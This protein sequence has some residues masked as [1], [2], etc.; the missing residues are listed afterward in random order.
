MTVA[1][2]V[3]ETVSSLAGQT[4]VTESAERSS[5]PASAKDVTKPGAPGTRTK[6]LENVEEEGSAPV[7]WIPVLN[8]GTSFTLEER[9][10]KRLEGLLPPAV[11]SLQLQADRVLLQLKE[12]CDT[13]LQ[14]YELLAQVAA[15]NETLFYKVLIDNITMLAP[16]VYTPTVGEACQK[17][18]RIYRQALGM[19]FDH[20]HYKGRFRQLLD[21]WPSHN[22]QIIVVTDG[23]RILGLG[24]L[25]T[26]G[27]GIPIGKISLY[28]SGGGFHPEHSLPAQLDCGTDNEELLKDRFYL[29]N[30]VPR[31]KGEAHMAVVDEFV[32]A[33]KDKWP[34]CLIQ[35]EDFQTDQAFKILEAYRDKVLCFNDDIQGTGAVVTSGFING[36]KAQGTPIAEARVVF[37]GAGSSAV[38]V[39][40]MIALLLQQEGGTSKEEAFKNIYMVDSKGLVTTSRGDELPEHKQVVARRDDVPN[41]KDLK[42]IIAHVKPHALIGLTGA[43]PSFDKDVV[44]EMCKHVERPLI[45]PLSNPTSKA[46]ITAEHA[47]EWSGGKAIFASGSPFDPYKYQGKVLEP[48]QANNV[49][50]FPGV[51]FGAV[52]VKSRTIQDEMLIAAAK[53]LADYVS[54]ED[55]KKGKIYPDLGELRDISAVVA[56]AVGEE[57]FRLGLAGIPKP[58]DLG[59]FIRSRMWLPGQPKFDPAK[60]NMQYENGTAGVEE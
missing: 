13:P 5:T 54:P 27:M 15:S 40:S 41:I 12:D 30:K 33:V 56:T 38:G 8:K 24:D 55:I 11:E 1:E 18:D 44:E 17:F 51:G 48:G 4:P 58:Q 2:A 9:K 29:G 23:G 35:F 59:K 37:Y 7:I 53:G 50:I 19:Y 31:L 25:G 46:E 32:M 6:A 26:N 22:V 57:A 47:Y 45:F 10:E 60:S 28:V 43:G 16:V 21:H 36:M 3:K 39:A 52:M 49:F 42:E 14:Q 20:V 34:D